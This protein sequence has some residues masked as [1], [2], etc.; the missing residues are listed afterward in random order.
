VKNWA[1]CKAKNKNQS[2]AR[3]RQLGAKSPL[4]RRR[5]E[6]PSRGK[7]SKLIFVC[8]ELKERRNI[9]LQIEKHLYNL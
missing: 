2:I 5:K 9:S 6:H 1:Q 7:K 8:E 3:A 4:L